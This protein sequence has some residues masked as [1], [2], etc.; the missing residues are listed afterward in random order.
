VSAGHDPRSRR[1]ERLLTGLAVA[2]GAGLMLL[3]VSRPW[4]HAVVHD[5]LAGQLSV[6]A[7]GRQAAPVVAAVALVALAGTVAVLTL[8]TVGRVVAGLLLVL[9]GAAA[10]AAALDVAR[11][12]S[13][14]LRSV[15]A[16]VTGRSGE[17][18]PVAQQTPWPWVAV[19]GAVVVVLA[20]AMAV[21]RARTWSSEAGLSGRY[22]SPVA[23]PRSHGDGAAGGDG[24]QEPDVPADVPDTWDRLSRGEDPTD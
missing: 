5:P 2:V 14:A 24:G 13:S 23:A 11:T 20:G 22:D 18:L 6:D 7:T 19:V 16:D 17:A 10:T 15:V 8:R 3:G 4:V 9:S 12:P 21:V 1:R